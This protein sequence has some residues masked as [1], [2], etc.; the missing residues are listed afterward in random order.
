MGLWMPRLVHFTVLEHSR[1]SRDLGQED[2]HTL[3]LSLSYRKLACQVASTRPS[4]VSQV[5]WLNRRETPILLV[6]SWGE[7]DW[8]LYTIKQGCETPT[9]LYT[10][11]IWLHDNERYLTSWQWEIRS[12]LLSSCHLTFLCS[13]HLTFSQ[14]LWTLCPPKHCDGNYDLLFISIIHTIDKKSN[15]KF[16]V[17]WYHTK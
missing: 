8:K 12:S 11:Y 6:G 16:S 9:R 15:H 4:F 13:C 1:S 3:L 7:R 17:R 14:L 2:F 5:R 10:L